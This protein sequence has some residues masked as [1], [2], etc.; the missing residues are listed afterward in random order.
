MSDKDKFQQIAISE[1][2]FDPW[3]GISGNPQE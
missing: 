1:A 2:G 3:S